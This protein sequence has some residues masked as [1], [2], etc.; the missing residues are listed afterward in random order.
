MNE[1]NTTPSIPAGY[2]RNAQGHLVPADT[3]KPV[4]D[5]RDELVNTLFDEARQLR[6][7]MAEFKLRAMQQIQGLC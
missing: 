4:D 1:Q 6:R 5:M 7:Q 2:R 3:I